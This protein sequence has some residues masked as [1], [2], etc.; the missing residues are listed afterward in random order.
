MSNSAKA[1]YD[2]LGEPVPAEVFPLE[3]F[4]VCRDVVIDGKLCRN[5]PISPLFKSEAVARETRNQL[6]QKYPDA[7]LCKS[8]RFF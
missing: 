7:G 5:H 6:I 1:I 2:K 4:W 3:T 8:V